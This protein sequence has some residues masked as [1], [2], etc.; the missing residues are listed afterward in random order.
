MCA[1]GQDC[2]TVVVALVGG[3]IEAC[4]PDSSG[5][6]FTAVHASVGAA[7]QQQHRAGHPVGDG[8]QDQGTA[9]GRADTDVAD[10]GGGPGGDGDEGDY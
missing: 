3:G 5:D 2:D 9:H 8:R 10:L 4:R 7:A 6:Q 1:I